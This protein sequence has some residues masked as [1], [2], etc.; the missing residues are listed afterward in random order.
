MPK[1]AT[2]KSINEGRKGNENVKK[3]TQQNTQK[4]SGKKEDKFE[5]QVGA[6]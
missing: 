4:N 3:A 5:D 2:K 1:D 6:C